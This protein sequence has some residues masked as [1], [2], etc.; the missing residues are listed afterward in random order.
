MSDPIEQAISKRDFTEDIFAMNRTTKIL[1]IHL[2]ASLITGCATTRTKYRP[3]SED[4]GY[5]EKKIDQSLYVARF[6]ANAYTHPQDALVFSKFRAIEVCQDNGFKFA[7]ILENR[8]RSTK[9]KIQ[10]TSNYNFQDPIYFNSNSKSNTNFNSGY[11]GKDESTTT[12]N[13]QIHGGNSYGGSQSWVDTYNYPT[14]DTIFSCTNQPLML[15]V[16]LR[17]ISPDDMKQ[18]VKDFMGG[19]Q[20]IKFNE[21]SP[22]E[23]IFQSADIITRVNGTRVQD[24]PQVVTALESA[25]DKNKIQITVVR[26]G[27]QLTLDAR[28]ADSTMII[29][30]EN[31]KILFAACSLSDVKIRPAC[32]KIIQ[33]KK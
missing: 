21:G 32:A 10:R 11:F 9:E 18:F 15:G 2:L 30:A 6:S 19:M 17:E 28:A 4:G 12:I 3:W 24:L 8:D 20:V 25:K 5:S 29:Q 13:G 7:R 1:Y 33:T 16:Q 14:F 27:K 22:N 23:G 26:D 31:E